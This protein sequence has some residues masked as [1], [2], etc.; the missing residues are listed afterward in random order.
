VIGIGGAGKQDSPRIAREPGGVSHTPR[1][2]KI[3]WVE[4]RSVSLY[5]LSPSNHIERR[6]D[7]SGLKKQIF[8]GPIQFRS[9]VESKGVSHGSGS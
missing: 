9:L 5:C 7:S 6:S 8:R 4:G 2:L 3:T 1:P